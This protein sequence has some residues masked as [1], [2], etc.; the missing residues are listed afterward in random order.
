MTP[1]LCGV[2]LAAKNGSARKIIGAI[3]KAGWLH[4]ERAS[5]KRDA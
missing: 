3:S 4:F 1:T 5:M 2:S